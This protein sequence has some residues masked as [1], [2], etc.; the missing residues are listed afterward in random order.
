MV[1][2]TGTSVGTIQHGV[3]AVTF[4]IN[5]ASGKKVWEQFINYNLSDGGVLVSVPDLANVYVSWVASNTVF[6]DLYRASN[7]G[8]IRRISYSPI[9]V[10]NHSSING[11]TIAAMEVSNSKG[12]YMTGTVKASDGIADFT[13][14]YLIKDNF[15]TRGMPIVEY[16]I[17]VEGDPFL[18][19]RGASLCLNHNNEHV[20]FLQDMTETYSSHAQENIII[21]GFDMQS[22]LRIQSGITVPES[23]NNK[24]KT[25]PSPVTDVLY[26][27]ANGEI[28]TIEITD[29]NGRLY[30]CK[31][32]ITGNSG[33]VDMRDAANGNYFIKVTESSGINSVARVIR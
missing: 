18:S 27:T 22:P 29:I 20:Y 19:R 5:S 16:E 26:V 15:S 13:G 17:P 12:I 8:L 14:S 1:Y 32:E 10:A 33:K 6:L 21:T 23:I 28:S 24:I 4:K 31:T 9:P 25:W 30:E 3:D 2:L 11:V 7:G